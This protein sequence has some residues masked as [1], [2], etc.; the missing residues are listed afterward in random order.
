MYNMSSKKKRETKRKKE[1]IWKSRQ[2]RKKEIRG[3]AKNIRERESG[4]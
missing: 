1:I 2:M 4:C 3:R